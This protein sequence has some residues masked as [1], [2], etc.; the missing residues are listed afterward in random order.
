MSQQVSKSGLPKSEINASCTSSSI[1]PLAQVSSVYDPTGLPR[2]EQDEKC[3]QE[4]PLAKKEKQ[5]E[6]KDEAFILQM[7]ACASLKLFG[8]FHGKKCV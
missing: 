3:M 8:E 6:K 1:A 7:C 5:V 4:G 2:Q